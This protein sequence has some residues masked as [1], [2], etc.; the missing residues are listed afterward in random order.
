MAKIRLSGLTPKSEKALCKKM[1]MEDL[2]TMIDFCNEVKSGKHT[3]DEYREME[4]KMAEKY[5]FKVK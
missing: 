2:K 4:L 1:S 5:G 3:I